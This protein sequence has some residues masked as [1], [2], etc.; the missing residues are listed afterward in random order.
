M[1]DQQLELIQQQLFFELGVGKIDLYHF[2]RIREIVVV[3]SGE[4]LSNE[5]ALKTFSY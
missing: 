2:E 3:R 1:N 5:T 4:I